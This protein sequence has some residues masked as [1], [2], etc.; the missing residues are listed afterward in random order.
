[1]VTSAPPPLRGHPTAAPLKP[2][3]ID[4]GRCVAPTLRGHPTAAPLKRG[5]VVVLAGAR[6]SLRGHPTAAPLKPAYL[7][8]VVV[9]LKPSAVIRPRPR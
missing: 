8:K 7:R 3:H 9:V 4:A 2:E 5:I 6:L 1:M